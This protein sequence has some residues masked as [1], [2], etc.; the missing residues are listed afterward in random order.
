M[1]TSL[2]TGCWLATVPARLLPDY[3]SAAPLSSPQ[4]G[5]MG[6]GARPSPPLLCN[7]RFLKAP[8]KCF[9][10]SGQPSVAKTGEE[11]G[12]R[13]QTARMDVCHGPEIG[14]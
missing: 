5:V 3:L 14:Q 2:F 9:T 11:Q 8:P 12:R 6:Q 13:K 10:V 7:P 1:H 4:L